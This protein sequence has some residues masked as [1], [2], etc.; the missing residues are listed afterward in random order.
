MG[1]ENPWGPH[2][3]REGPGHQSQNHLDDNILGPDREE[4]AERRM[5]VG[6]LPS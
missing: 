1:D 6:A 3:G 5:G 4:K 2:W